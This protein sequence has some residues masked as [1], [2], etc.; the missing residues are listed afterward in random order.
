MKILAVDTAS[1]TCSVALMDGDNVIC[2]YTVNHKDTH[3]RFVMDMIH[4]ALTVSRLTI[5]ELDGFAVTIGPGSFT[6]LRIG[7]STVKGL[8]MAAD[9]PA[10]GVS[11]LE[12]LARAVWPAD[13][14]T[15]SAA[16]IC[17]MMD[18]RR[19]EVYAAQYQWSENALICK[20][21]PAALPPAAAV[22]A[23]SGP[24]VFTG[25]G[26]VAYQERIRSL[27][28]KHAVFTDSTFQYIR[29][30]IVG[31]IAV[32]RFS[33]GA[34]VPADQLQPLYLRKSDAEKNLTAS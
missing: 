7:L 24:C 5:P 15:G 22:E 20:S 16:L 26:A 8:A 1:K 3:S 12:A 2:E 18:A 29:A 11:S 33:K 6:G 17:P 13:S 25:D 9:K 23:I 31:R 4:T 28:G 10:V 14:Q 27:L 32:S 21:L 19:R 30:A 34:A